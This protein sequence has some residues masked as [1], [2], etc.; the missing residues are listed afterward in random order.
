MT[1]WGD[2]FGSRDELPPELKDKSPQEIAAALKKAA[3]DATALQKLVDD[4]KLADDQLAARNSEFE[5][6]KAK[7]AQ[8]EANP[9]TP[10]PGKP[11]VPPEPV[12]P[13]VDPA[14]FVQDQVK[15]LADT[16]LMAGMMTAKMYCQQGLNARDAKIFKKYETEIINLVG[17]AAPAQRVMPQTW[18]NML[19]FVKGA[20][21]DDIRKA[22]ADKTDFFSE[23]PSHG[24][25]PPEPPSDK[26]TPEEEEVCRKFHYDPVKY[27]ARKKSGELMQGEKGAYGRYSVPQRKG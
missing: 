9:P 1:L 12:S 17:T 7:L 8:L 15:P 23:L 6:L 19:M 10:P 24:G 16:A 21:E 3:D 4:K 26:L 5:Q 22:E 20:H 18:F 27:L 11:P 25:P 14:G 2:R 13:W